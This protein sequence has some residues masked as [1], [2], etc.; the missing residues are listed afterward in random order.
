[1]YLI[2]ILVNS[3][4]KSLSLIFFSQKNI[5]FKVN[6]D[7]DLLITEAIAIEYTTTR[8]YAINKRFQDIN[9]VLIP[10]TF[11]VRCRFHLR[12][13]EPRLFFQTLNRKS[14]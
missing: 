9:V 4:P 11:S 13:C 3:T 12:F 6:C 10:S 14:R 8:R 7:I 2:Y 1:M 5:V